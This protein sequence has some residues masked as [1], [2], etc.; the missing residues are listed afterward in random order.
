MRR[1]RWGSC[2]WPFHL[3]RNVS[4]SSVLHWWRSSLSR[5]GPQWC[6]LQNYCQANAS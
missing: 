6:P 3:D 4:G 1:K 2:V 5:G